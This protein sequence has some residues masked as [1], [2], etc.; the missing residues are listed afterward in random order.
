MAL[1]VDDHLLP[2]LQPVDTQAKVHQHWQQQV[3]RQIVSRLD[4]QVLSTLTSVQARAEVRREGLYQMDHL[5]VPLSAAERQEILNEI[6]DDM[7]GLGPLEPLLRDPKISDIMVNGPNHIYVERRGHLEPVATRFRDERHLHQTIDRLVSRSGRRLDESSP[8]VDTRLMDGSRVNAIIHP[9]ALDGPVLSIRRFPEEHL[10]LPALARMGAFPASLLG[11][12]RNMV[13]SRLNILISGGTGSGKTTLLNALSAAID[14]HERVITVEDAAELQLQQPHVVRLESRPANIEGQGEVTL[15]DLV[16][17]SLRMRPD[18]IVVGEV[19]GA[20]FIDMLTAMN[21]GHD[22]SMTTLH[23]NSPADAVRRL[24]SMAAMS[25]IGLDSEVITELI[26]SAINV[27]VQLER[28]EDGTRRVTSIQELVRGEAEVLELREICRFERCHVLERMQVTDLE[29]SSI[30]QQG[31]TKKNVSGNFI[32][33]GYFPDF[34]KKFEVRGLE[35]DRSVFAEGV[36][37]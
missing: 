3:H 12:M 10:T 19:R 7:L 2:G 16:R 11:V 31:A 14:H 18:R 33:M 9:L 8:M 1:T 5:S 4:L 27:I 22:G 23:A 15:R 36:L 13:K 28:M 29:Q 21:T 17:N 35:I 20:E 34:L 25:G 37:K 30:D 24:K 6:C 32:S 26:A